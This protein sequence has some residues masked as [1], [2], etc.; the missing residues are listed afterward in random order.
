MWSSLWHA[1][2]S[3]H[4]HGRREKEGTDGGKEG[5]GERGASALGFRDSSAPPGPVTEPFSTAAPGRLLAGSGSSSLHTPLAAPAANIPLS[6][7]HTG[8]SV[9]CLRRGLYGFK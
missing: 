9:I 6:A 7:Q 8:I 4:H 5:G 1:G 3:P 2:F